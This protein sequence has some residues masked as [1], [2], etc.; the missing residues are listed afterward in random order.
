MVTAIDLDAAR[1]TA[2]ALDEHLIECR[3]HMIHTEEHDEAVAVVV[4]DAEA[5]AA[6]VLAMADRITS[7]EAS[8]ALLDEQGRKMKA[9]RDEAERRALV[10]DAERALRFKKWIEACPEDWRAFFEAE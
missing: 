2:L 1:K 6:L 7:L 10:T 5:L 9:E 3:E 4:G 8:V